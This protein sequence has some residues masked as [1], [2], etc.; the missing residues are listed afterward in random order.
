MSPSDLNKIMQEVERWKQLKKDA[1]PGEWR[2]NTSRSAKG[3]DDPFLFVGE[4]PSLEEEYAAPNDEEES[5]AVTERNHVLRYGGCGSHA[6]K[7]SPAD[8]DFIAYA[9]N[10]P[11]EEYCEQL[12]TRLREK[13]KER[14]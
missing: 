11:I 5:G 8:Q 6:L 13:E 2:W 12:I 7:V 4:L 1:M 9:H 3:I 10:T 14:P